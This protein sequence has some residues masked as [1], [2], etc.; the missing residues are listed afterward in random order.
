MAYIRKSYDPDQLRDYS[1]LFSRSEVARLVEEGRSRIIDYCVKQYDST[2]FGSGK[3]YGA[4]YKY[5]YKVLQRYYANEYIYK[6]EFINRFL[7]P[8]YA[9]EQCYTYSELNIGGVI[10][11]LATFNGRS[12]GYEIKTALD[13]PERL[14]HQMDCYQ[15]VF[16]QVYVVCPVDKINSYMSA[17]DK[18]VGVISYDACQR[19]FVLVRTSGERLGPDPDQ[20]M[21][22]LL[23]REYRSV[24]ETYYGPE[25]L[26]ESTDFTLFRD[27]KRLMREIPP[28]SLSELFI[29]VMKSRRS[30]AP[31]FA[32]RYTELNQLLIANRTD[33]NFMDKLRTVLDHPITL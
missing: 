1:L 26:S 27:C 8:H 18:Y 11:D 4:Y 12:I 19:N 28:A 21:E 13:S 3:T 22:V 31:R 20:L 25:I 33:Q 10:A 9:G 6:N 17:I 5:L 32:K 7:Y 16:N 15:R 2:A 24:I 14:R 30:V 29:S 23:T